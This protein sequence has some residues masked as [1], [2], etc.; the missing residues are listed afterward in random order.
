MELWIIKLGGSIITEKQEGVPVIRKRLVSQLCEKISNFLSENSN[1]QIILL[2]GAGSIG[3]PLAKEYDL[4]NNL[5]DSKRIYGMAKTVLAMRRLSNHIASTLQR[6]NV[7]AIPMQ[8]GSM[9]YR[10]ENNQLVFASQLILENMFVAHSVPILS[11]DVVS[12]RNNMSSIASADELAVVLAKTFN[13]T[14]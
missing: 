10:N 5:L 4:S 2:H 9:F 11:G 14:R 13:A 1:I 3:H 6:Y 8:T 7:P 12:T